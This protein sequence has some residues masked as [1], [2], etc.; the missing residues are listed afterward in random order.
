MNDLKPQLAPGW[1]G[2]N[3]ALLVVLFLVAAPLGLLMLAYILL[4]ARLGLD[5]SRP[6]TFVSAWDRLVGAWKAGTASWGG[7]NAVPQGGGTPA[8]HLDR[9]QELEQREAAL[10][11]ERDKL[12]RE[13]ADFERQKSATH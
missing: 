6:H 5:L 13:R 11:A 1:S 8:P 9:A 10:L 2:V 12:A 4:G 3:I 7:D